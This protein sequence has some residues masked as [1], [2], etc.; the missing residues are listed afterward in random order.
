MRNA[1]SFY[2]SYLASMSA[3]T[4]YT[5]DLSG[6]AGGNSVTIS[7]KSGGAFR[8]TLDGSTPTAFSTAA[9]D[10]GG[11]YLNG[12]NVLIEAEGGDS[13]TTVKILP[14]TDAWV[15]CIVTVSKQG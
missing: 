12:G 9:S 3:G 2:N 6:G 5:F 11:L 4:V 15:D 10:D 13:V 14:V 7:N 8:F 1:E